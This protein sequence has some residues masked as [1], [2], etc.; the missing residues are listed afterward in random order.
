VTVQELDGSFT[1]II[2][3][4]DVF[5]R[6]DIQCHSKARRQRKR[7]IPLWTGEEVPFLT[8]HWV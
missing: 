6:H 5:S 8:R 4:D 7:K 2:Q 1:H 3:I